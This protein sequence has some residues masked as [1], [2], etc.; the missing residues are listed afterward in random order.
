MTGGLSPGKKREGPMLSPA[1]DSPDTL[2]SPAS[3][4]PSPASSDTSPDGLIVKVKF[5]YFQILGDHS[6]FF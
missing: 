1:L 4:L 3:S 5:V 6:Y 2:F